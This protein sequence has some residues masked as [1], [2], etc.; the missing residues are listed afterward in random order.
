MKFLD[1]KALRALVGLSMTHITRLEERELFPKRF[2]LS[3]GISKK[4]QPTGRVFWLEE[5]VLEWMKERVKKP[6]PYV[7]WNEDDSD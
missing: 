7:D 1:K 3:E 6:L 4:G 5:P 2:R